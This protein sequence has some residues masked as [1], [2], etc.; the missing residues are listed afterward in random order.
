M[1]KR[2]NRTSGFKSKVVLEALQERNTLQEIA[3]KYDLHPNQITT[4]KKQFL[5]GA[6][7]VFEKGSV[8]I[9]EEDKEKTELYKKVGQLQME[10]DFLK[11]VLGK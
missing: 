9:N 8:V 5:L 3:R 2:G 10:I 4:W 7:S 6:S 11:K 1:K